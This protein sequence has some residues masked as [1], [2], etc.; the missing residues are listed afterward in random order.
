MTKKK[1]KFWSTMIGALILIG[2]GGVYLTYYLS[3][4]D[5]NEKGKQM[6]CKENMEQSF[7]GIVTEINRYDYDQ[8]MN[9]NFFALSIKTN[10]TT[11]KF[12][13]Y[14]FNLE[15]SKNILDFA[16]VGLTIIKK[17]NSDSFDI[18]DNYGIKR[19]FKIPHCD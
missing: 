3:M 13:D 1:A 4:K 15:Q 10:D 8:F 17:Q 14:Q 9:K 5:A 6:K 12:I 11:I 19:T 7:L 2:F 18:I 16:K